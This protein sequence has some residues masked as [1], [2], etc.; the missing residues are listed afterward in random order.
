MNTAVADVTEVKRVSN[1]TVSAE[2]VR[3]YS[4]EEVN[5]PR[6]SHAADIM[7]TE[8]RVNRLQILP[9]SFIRMETR[10]TLFATKLK[11]K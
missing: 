4:G 8:A 5:S 2:K 10:L 3:R 11:R 9:M 1:F 6:P 7:I